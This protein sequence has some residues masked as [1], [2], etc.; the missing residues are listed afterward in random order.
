[1]GWGTLSPGPATS[2]DND[3]IRSEAMPRKWTKHAQFAGDE[4]DQFMIP[5]EPTCVCY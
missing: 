3:I 5:M 4:R 1:M 2:P